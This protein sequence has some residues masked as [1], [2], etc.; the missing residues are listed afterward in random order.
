MS[1]RAFVQLRSLLV[2]AILTAGV[3]PAAARQ[4]PASG[5]PTF[6]SGVDLVRFDV[7]VVDGSG[8]PITDLR[9]D[10]IEVYEDGKRLPVVLFQRITEPAGTYVDEARRAVTA[11]VSSNEAFPRGHL[12]ILIFDQQHITPG[13]E[14]R[15]RLAAE[16]FLRT[17]V[18][19]SDRV[20][21]FALPGPGPQ[22]DFTTDKLRVSKALAGIRGT[23]ERIVTTPQLTMNIYEAHRIVHGDEKLVM[24]A[25]ERMSAEAVGDVTGR[26]VAGG[27]TTTPGSSA[28]NE[29]LSISR[30]LVREN[31]QAVVNRTDN[32]SRQL[33][34]RLADVILGFRD[35]EGRKTVVFFTEGFFQ[36]NLTRELESVAAAAAQSYSVFYPF[37]LNQ[38][39]APLNE[40][41]ATETPQGSEIQARIAAL[42][43]LAV[44]TDG[45]LIL[46][47][48]NR[49]DKV[50]DLLAEQ[51]R[52]YYL[53]GFSPSE[54]ARSERGKYRRVSI[55]VKRP[56]ASASAR[57]GYA[58]PR[59]T[60]VADK[61]R[62]INTV[63]GAPFV[64][65]GLKI[66]YTTYV[67][68]A[69]EAGRHRVVLSLN[70]D[71]PVRATA[72]DAA[73]VVF[74]ARDVRDGRVVASGTDTIPLPA[75]AKPGA[76]I[77]S[78][79]WRVQFNVP[80]GSY[81][82]RAV[83]REPGGLAG[84]ADRRLD[85]R[86]LDGPEVAVSDLVLGSA[87][88]ALPVKPRAF[89]GDGL[90]GLLEAYARTD[91]QMQD[92]NVRIELRKPGQETSIRAI[93]ADL[94]A[95]EQ[96]GGGLS[97]KARFLMP[98]EGIEPGEYTAHA[99]VKARGEIVA[100]RT[101]HVE[102]L[103][104]RSGVATEDVPNAL[105]E[106]VSPLDVL[107][108]DL[109]RRFVGWLQGRAQ[110]PAEVEAARR[111]SEQRWEQ[112]ELQVQRL[113]DQRGVVP[114]ALRGLALFARED[115]AGA[116]EA[117]QS[118]FDAEAQSSLT[119]FFLGWAHEGAGHT[120]EAISAWRS[121]AHLDPTMVSAHIALADAYLR[122]SE[123]ALA[124]QAIR[125]G[126]T[127][128]PDSLELRERLARLEKRGNR[129]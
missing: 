16:Q 70:A 119:A 104:A 85:V 14:Q 96:D 54:D 81:L 55:K 125:A 80:A 107:G 127:A 124:L 38:R 108:G 44:E 36:D 27:A 50:L 28:S 103:A 87:L 23:Y 31:A 88:A 100:E 43:T 126:L 24:G 73:D 26:G 9:S 82:M 111:A 18:R 2:A 128:L 66:D 8:R 89:T 25:I 20:A 60:V 79:S 67:M 61:K 17:R 48:A 65:Q 110:G 91:V 4:E 112:V 75:N 106:R 19:P 62:A 59:E 64:Q 21:L 101:R 114:K 120:R 76:S 71:L 123:P 98:L 74:V 13:N 102:V 32:E 115:F 129:P 68:K 63:L 109:G 113:A 7:R 52:D 122:L 53:V 90:S 116:A 121:A 86:P 10:E 58:L 78:S 117:L 51:A 94:Q 37:D 42:G 49:S 83:V 45:N 5:Q 6:K 41:F 46:D 69:P 11:E 40:A 95:T 39:T 77:G 33:L 29:D 99:I 30:R 118:A 15:A 35:I 12:Y 92:L 72:G 97:R 22:I 34:Q 105:V 57:T 1:W 84:S 47:A 3:L 56:G 93:D